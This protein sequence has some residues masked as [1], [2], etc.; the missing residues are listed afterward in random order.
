MCPALGIPWNQ[1]NNIEEHSRKKKTP[2]S[3][4]K[5]SNKTTDMWVFFSVLC[6]KRSL[7]RI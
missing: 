3:L 5:Q 6:I 4:F 7:R 2:F 1:V